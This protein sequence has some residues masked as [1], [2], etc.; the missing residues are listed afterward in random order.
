MREIEH[1]NQFSKQ[2]KGNNYVL[3]WRNL[4]IYNPKSLLANIECY[5]KFEED[6]S[7]N[8]QDREQKQKVV[9]DGW[10]DGHSTQIFERRV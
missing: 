10:T 3:I 2:I 8:A 1:W 5:A 4:P 6:L 7:R 9:T